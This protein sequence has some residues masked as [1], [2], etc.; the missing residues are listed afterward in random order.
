MF[1]VNG[2]PSLEKIEK[3][4]NDDN[5]FYRFQ[6]PTYAIEGDYTNSWGMIYG[7]KEEAIEAWME[8]MECD[9]DEAEEEAILPGKSCMTTFESIVSF[10]DRFSQSDVLLIFH[11]YDTRANGHDD[12]YVA[13]Y[14]YEIEVWSMEDV[15][16][17]YNANIEM[18]AA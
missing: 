13:D 5:V 3:F 7:T 11:G 15:I 4:D 10:S 14:D 2:K 17:F 18:I 6:N 9:Y 12:E 8:D 1:K 16:D